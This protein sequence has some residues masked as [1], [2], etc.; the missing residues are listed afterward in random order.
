MAQTLHA[1]GGIFVKAIPTVL[2]LVFLHFYF[3]LM[4]FGPLKK[5][6]KRREELTE[7]ARKIAGESQAFA[8]RKA[9]E[10]E[11]KL[12][13]ARAQVY[14][15]QEETRK[16]WLDDQVAQVAEARKRNEELVKQTRYEIA[17][18]AAG[19][20][21]T[22]LGTTSALAEEIAT[23][24]LARRASGSLAGGSGIMSKAES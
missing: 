6:L 7:G 20:R 4:L 8:D 22:L 15:A 23:A 1:L 14:R 9:A 10:Y 3:K 5:V 11:A 17:T 2:L 12:R 16:R 21:Q 19:A 13:D 24:V 18:E